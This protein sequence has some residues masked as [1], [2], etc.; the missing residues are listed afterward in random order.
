[1]FFIRRI[2]GSSMLPTIKPQQTV[3]FKKSHQFKPGQIV[4]VIIGKRE[5]VKRLLWQ[6]N[7]KAYLQGDNHAS[8]DYYVDLRDLKGVLIFKLQ[9]RR[10]AGNLGRFAKSSC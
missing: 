9:S 8:A 3:V 7:K 5:I 1:M 2:I 10:R 4:L 6:T